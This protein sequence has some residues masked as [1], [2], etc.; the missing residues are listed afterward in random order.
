M[1]Q[2]WQRLSY[3]DK[4]K[5]LILRGVHLVIEL[6]QLTLVIQ[7][8]I[9]LS[10]MLSG[11][12]VLAGDD[13]PWSFETDSRV[14]AI[15][16]LHGDLDSLKQILV[17]NKV[18]DRQGKWISGTDHLVLNGDLVNL[19]PKSFELL[20][21]VMELE[22]QASLSR[23]KVHAILGNHEVML[24]TGKFNLLSPQDKK[25]FAEFAAPGAPYSSESLFA[26][27]TGDSL[28][29]KWLR[30]RNS[31]IR[32]N[33]QIF[34][35]A[36]LDTWMLNSDPGQINY[37]VRAWL[38]RSQM[39]LS[40]EPMGR[41]D[42]PPPPETKK[43]IEIGSGP[44]GTSALNDPINENGS[45]KPAMSV[46][47]LDLILRQLNADSI[48]VGHIQTHDQLISLLHSR[49]GSRVIQLDTGISEAE[50]GRLSALIMQG[51]S[52]KSWHLDRKLISAIK[53]CTTAVKAQ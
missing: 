30:S 42:P 48:A 49:Y 32:I 15:G 53:S 31:I 25:A 43:L 3:F 38:K 19:G 41:L 7:F 44:G 52:L 24:A 46:E 2:S 37:L 4:G 5:R 26:A 50:K 17:E 1:V 51:S 28:Y 35:H 6:H 36:G 21:F 23:G 22:K 11:L 18:I 33:R 29:A 40:P 12:P 10:L 13:I 16:D 47:I 27:L 45:A 14:I 34:V 8:L 20:N 39:T 9:V